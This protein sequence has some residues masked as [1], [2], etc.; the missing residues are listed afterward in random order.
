[1][2][3]HMVYIENHVRVVNIITGEDE[4]SGRTTTRVDIVP[5]WSGDVAVKL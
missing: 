1:M 3:R 4:D 2:N 5:D